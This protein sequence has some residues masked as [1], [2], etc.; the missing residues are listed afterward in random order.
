[1][2][3]NRYSEEFRAEAV[4]LV[5]QGRT[6]QSV[7]D[8]L[9]CSIYALRTWVQKAQAAN[10][11]DV[12]TPAERAEIRELKAQLAQVRMERDLLKKAC[13]VFAQDTKRP[14]I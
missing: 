5:L 7:A 1:M 6:Y 12:V 8:A 13:A 14:L 10:D 3:R 11:P 2:S 4:Q 9:G